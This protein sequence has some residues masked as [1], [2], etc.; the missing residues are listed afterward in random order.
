[1]PV[2]E[3]AVLGT[4]VTG[5]WAVQGGGRMACWKAHDVQAVFAINHVAPFS[6]NLGSG[7]VFLFLYL[8]LNPEMF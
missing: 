3:P 7:F 4:A 2:R 5:L 8:S 6:V 1:M